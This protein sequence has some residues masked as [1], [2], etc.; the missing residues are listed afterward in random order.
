MASLHKVSVAQNQAHAR[1]RESPDQPF[2]LDWFT[3]DSSKDDIINLLEARQGALLAIDCAK[4]EVNESD[5]SD[6]EWKEEDCNDDKAR[7]K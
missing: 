1:C 2:A 4:E 5:E 6:Q 3:A 7:G